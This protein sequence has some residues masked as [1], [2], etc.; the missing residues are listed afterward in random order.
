MSAGKSLTILIIVGIIFCCWSGAGLAE[1]WKY[2]VIKDY[3]QV[4]PLPQASIQ[5]DKNLHYKV[6]FDIKTGAKK[7]DDL[8]PGLHHMARLI[9]LMGLADIKPENYE[10]VG[11]ISG[12]AGPAVLKN[13]L[14]R[15]KFKRDNP[16]IGLIKELKKAGTKLYVCGQ[17]LSDAGYQPDCVNPEIDITLSAL[18]A[19]P[20]L[21][22]RGYALLPF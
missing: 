20:T 9:N 16:N 14:Y 4:Q 18:V 7:P 21:E 11:V 1:S 2:P 6:V 13:D 12:Y 15:K 3:G 8:N 22:L 17:W 19:V 10:I 5:P